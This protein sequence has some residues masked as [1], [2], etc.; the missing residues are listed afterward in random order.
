MG[1]RGRGRGRGRKTLVGICTRESSCN[2]RKPYQTGEALQEYAGP[3]SCET[4]CPSTVRL[5]L[6]HQP[7]T[8]PECHFDRFAVVG[9][10]R[11]AQKMCPDLLQVLLRRSTALSAFRRITPNVRRTLGSYGSDGSA[12]APYPRL[13]YRSHGSQRSPAA[14]HRLLTSVAE[15]R[16]EATEVRP[17]ARLSEGRIGQPA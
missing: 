7:A 14:G 10:R 15:E 16:S 6:S 9:P 1:G 5:I 8:V 17:R 11:S 3:F 4:C 2:E 12:K 13:G